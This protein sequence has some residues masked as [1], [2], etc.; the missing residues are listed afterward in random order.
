MNFRGSAMECS[1]GSVVPLLS[2]CECTCGRSRIH[3]DV[4]Q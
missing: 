4:Q 2:V 3:C 1:D